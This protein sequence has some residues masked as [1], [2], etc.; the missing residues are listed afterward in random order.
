MRFTRTRQALL[1]FIYFLMTRIYLFNGR[2]FYDPHV[3]GG[4]PRAPGGELARPGDTLV[5]R[6]QAHAVTF[7]S[8]V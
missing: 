1:S 6:G 3:A 4:K 7:Q 8:S 2:Y 5:S